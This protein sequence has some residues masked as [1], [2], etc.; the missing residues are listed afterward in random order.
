MNTTTRSWRGL[1]WQ[2]MLLLAVLF[3]WLLPQT[4]GA[5]YVDQTY[6]Y[7]VQLSG[8]NSISFSMPVYDQED[9][10][11]WILDGLLKAKWKDDDGNE[12][13]KTVLRWQR[14]LGSTSSS[15]TDVNIVFSTEADGLI[16]ITQGNSSSRFELTN[17]SG[18]QMHAVYRNNDGHSYNVTGV[19]RLPFDMLGSEGKSR[20]VKFSWD[21]DRTGTGTRVHEKVSGLNSTT[22]TVPPAENKLYP[23]VTSATMSF[24]KPGLLEVPWF[25]AT[26][27]LTA[28]R[29]E[30]IDADGNTVSEELKID[31][32]NGTIDLDATVPHKRF[33]VVVS[34]KDGNDYDVTNVPSVTQDLGIIRAPIGFMARPKGDDKARVELTWKTLYPD[35]TDLMS[36]DLF[37]L[38]RSLTGLEADF[39]TIGSVAY[40]DKV[41]DYSFVDSTIVTSLNTAQLT[42][43]GTLP[44]LTYRVR[45]AATQSWGWDGNPC[46]ASSQA[47]V[48]GLHLLRLNTY[49]AKWEDER[50]H[51][52]RVNWEYADEYHAV[53]DNRA[54]LMMSV[55]M[56]N[57]AGEVV[58]TKTYELTDDERNAR[59]KVIDLSRSC[60]KYDIKMYVDPGT[61]PLKNY[62]D[63]E[64]YYFPIRNAT[65]WQTFLSK[66][67]EAKGQY[68]VNARLYADISTTQSCGT[69]TS[70]FRG[71]FD[72]NGHTLTVN[73]S[74]SANNEAPFK[75][76]KDYTIECLTVA[77]TVKG[78]RH[79]AGLVGA[80]YGSK[81]KVN[82]IRSCRV[83]ATVE[84]VERYVGGFIGHGYEANHHIT[85]CLFDGKMKCDGSDTYGGV[86]IGWSD[87]SADNKVACCLENGTFEGITYP[88]MNFLGGKASFYDITGKNNNNC[89][90]HDWDPALAANAIYIASASDW[91]AFAKELNEGKHPTANVKL[92]ADIDLS[93]SNPDECILGSQNDYPFKGVFDGAGHTLNVNF[94]KVEAYMAP[95][96]YVGD[97]TIKNL[98]V[99]GIIKG[100][101][102]NSGLIGYTESN[103]NVIIEKVRVSAHIYGTSSVSAGFIAYAYNLPNIRMFDCLYDGGMHMYGGNN[104]WC[105]AMIGTANKTPGDTWEL[106]RVYD[107]GGYYDISKSLVGFCWT[108]DGWWNVNSKST[109]CMTNNYFLPKVDYCADQVEVVRRMN[110][111]EEGSWVLLNRTAVPVLESHNVNK[112]LT[113]LGSGWHM[114]EGTALPI[115][116]AFADPT[117][118][119]PTP[120]LPD[121]YHQNTG[122]VD[123]KLNTQT[124]QS[125]VVLTWTTDGNPIDYFQVMRRVKGTTKWEMI[126][127]QVDQMAYEDTTVLALTDY[128]YQVKGVNDCEGLHTSETDVTEGACKHSG[129][130]SGYVRMNDGTSVAGIEVEIAPTPSDSPEGGATVTVTT[131]DKGYFVADELSYYG[132]QSI[133]YNVTPVARDNIKLE[134]GTM[135]VEF[136]SKSNDE[137]LPDFIITSGHRFSGYVMYE[138]T[139]IPVKGAHF[140]VDGH[141]VH[142]AAGELLETAFDGSFSFRV[143]GGN[144][145]IQ[146]VMDSHKFA[147]DG[148]FKGE[149]GY[150]FSDNVAQ[151]Y[152]YDQTKVKLTGRIVGGDKQGLLPFDNNLSRNNLGD[153]LTM[154][155]TLEGDNT[156]WLIYDNLNPSLSSR[157]DSIDH[158]GGG[159][160]KTRYT[161]Q[162]KRMEVHPDSITG[163]YVLMLPPVRWKVQQVYCDGYATLFQDGQVS[164]VVD[165]TGCLDPKETTYAGSYAYPDGSSISEPKATYNAIYSRI[166]HAPV[167]ITY[168]QLGYD[169]F[170]YFGDKTYRAQSLSSDPVDVPLVYQDKQQNV[171]YTFGYPL[172]SLE[173][174]YPIE[175][176]VAERYIYNNDARTGKVDIVSVGGGSVTVHNGLKNGLHQQTVPLDA[177]GLGHFYL[178][179]EQT[180]RLLTGEDAL[181]TVTMTLT[182]DGTTYEAEPLQGY[183]M[184]TFAM[185]GSKDIIAADEPLLIDILRDPPGSGSSATLSKGSKLKLGYTVDMKFEAGVKLNFGKG[186]NLD[187]YSGTVSGGVSEFGQ[188]TSAETT[189][190]V[191]LDIIFSG[192]GTKGYS[193]TMNVNEDITTS[194]APNMVG[195]DADLYIGVVHNIVVQ[196]MSTIRAIPDAMY[197]QMKG[198]VADSLAT[199]SN[200]ALTQD[201]YGSLVHIAEGRDADKN[202]YHLVRDVSLGYGPKLKSQFVYSQRHIVN[203]LIPNL[204]QEIYSMI[205]TGTKAEAEA[206][207]KATGKTVYWSKVPVSDKNFGDKDYYAMITP[208]GV[209]N[210]IDTLQQKLKNL[211][212]WMNMIAMNEKDKISAYDLVANYAVDGGSSVT[213]SEEFESNYSKAE[214]VKYPFT[215]ADYFGE[216]NV[217]SWDVVAD[218]AASG[219]QLVGS[220]LLEMLAKNL[221]GTVTSDYNESHYDENNRRIIETSLHFAGSVFKCG[222]TPVAEY[223]STG[224]GSVENAFSRKES[225]TLSLASKSHLDVDVFRVKPLSTDTLKAKYD[226]YFDVF[227]NAKFD[228]W[229]NS[230]IN[231][232]GEGADTLKAIYPRSFVYR[233]RGGATANPWEDERR[234]MV[235]RPGLLLDERTKKISNPK[236]KMNQQSVSGVPMGEAA[237]FKVYLSNESEYPEAATGGLSVFNLYLD[238]ASNPNGAKIYVDGTPL[239]SQGIDV[240][241]APGEQVTKTME[242]YAGDGFDYDSLTIALTQSS[243]WIH[244]YDEVRFDVHFLHEAGPVLIATPGDKWI[245]NTDAEYDE[246]RG[247]F[248]PVTISGFNKH[249]HNFDHIEFQYKESQRGDGYWTNLCS[250]FADETLMAKASGERKMIP[251]NDNIHAHFY[252]EGTV[253]EKAYDL[254]A[255]LYCRNGNSFLTTSSPIVSGVKDTRRPQLFG[256]PEPKDG[257]LRLGDNI[258]FNFSEDIEYNYLNAITNF[259]VKGEVNND[260][261]TDAV[262]VQFTGNGSVESEAQRNFS[263]KDLTIDLMVRPDKTGR[264]MPL[265]SH[266][267]NGKRLQLWLTSDFRLKAII[268]DQTFLSTDTIVKSGFTQVAMV[269]D[270]STLNIDHS[271]ADENNGQSSM[272]NGQSSMVNG[273]SSMVNGQL[274]FYNG[275]KQLG[276]FKMTEPYN[277]TGRLIFGRTNETDRSKSQYYEGRMMEAR[278]WYR[279]MTGGQVGTTYGSRRLTGYEMGL[280]DYF[281]M[282]EGTGD[283]ALDKTQGA[284]AQLMGASW[285]MPRGWSL[286]LDNGGV[287]LTQQALARTA[288]QDYTMM[289]WFKT[290]DADGTLVSNGS[291]EK[292]EA[293]AE[294]HFWL[295][296][297]DGTL[298]FRSNGMTVE[299]GSG[300]NDDQWHHYAM[301]VNRTRGVANIYVDQALKATFSPDSLGGISGGTP[302]IGGCVRGVTNNTAIAP[303]RAALAEPTAD[304]GKTV[305]LSTLTSAYEAKDGDVLTGTL[306]AN[307]K[308][309]VANGATVTLSDVTINGFNSTALKWAGINCEGNATIILK[310]TNSVQGFY[311]DYPGIYV[312][313]SKTLTIKGDGS[314]TAKSSMWGAAG[315]GGGHNISCGNI[316]IEGGT[317]TTPGG[318][319]CAGIG[320]GEGGSCGNITI[321]GGTINATGGYGSAGIGGGYSGS[322][323]NITITDGV[324]SVTATKG[325]DAPYSIGSSRDG[326]CGIVTIG[327]TVGTISK[328]PYTYAPDYHTVTGVTLN[329]VNT[330]LNVGSSETLTATVI[331]DN[332]SDKS[333]TWTTSNAA[334]ATVADGTVTAVTPGTATITVTA[335]NG[336]TAT[337]EVTVIQP[338]TGVTLNKV[339]TTLA[340]GSTETLT[341]TVYPPNATD[342][343]LTWTTSNAAVATVADGVVTAVATGT[344]TITVTTAY[345]STATCEVTVPHPVRGVSLNKTSTTL[346]IGGKETLIAIVIPSN[347][348]KSVTWTTSNA[349]VATVTDGVVTGVN[350]GTATITVTTNDGGKT[351][352]CEVTVTSNRL[353]SDLT[354]NI[355]EL[356]MFQQALPLTLIEAYATKSPQGDEA[357]L[358]TYLAFDRQERQKDNDIETVAYTWSKKIYLDDRGEVRYELDPVTKQATTTPV[359]DYLFVGSADE[360]LRHITNETAAPVVPYEELTNLKFSFAGKDNQVLVELDELAS[361]INRRNIYVTLRDVEDKNGNAM[362]SPQTAC[363]YVTNSSLRW[364]NERQTCLASYGYEDY[365]YFDILNNSATTHTYTIENCPRWLDME[366]YTGIIGPLGTVT[367]RGVVNK[368][369]NVGTYDEIIYLTDE[370]GVAEPLYLNLTV[371]TSAPEWSWSVD[372]DLLK[373]SMNIAG[374]VILNGE[375]DIDSRDIVGVF[376]RENRCH[377]IAHV[378]YSALTGESDLFLTVY[379]SKKKGTELYFKIWQYSTGREMVLTADG[380][381]SMTFRNDSIVGVDTPVRFEGG[382]LYVQTFDLKEGWNWVSFNVASEKLFD[383]NTLLGGLPWENGDVLTEMSGNVTMTYKNGT[384]LATGDVK[385]LRISPRKGYAIKVAQDIQ[386]PVGG[387]IIKSEDTRTIT[388][389]NGWNGIGYTPILNLS[390]ETALSD[391]YDNATPGDIIK[392]HSEFAYFTKTGGTGR[393]RGNLQYMKPGEGYMLLRKAEGE[394]SFRYPFYEPGSTFLDAWAVA[395]SRSAAEDGSADVPSA[396]TD[397]NGNDATVPAASPLG[398]HRYRHTMSLTAVI[399]G[400]EPEE[401]DLLVAY[402]DGE[403]CAALVVGHASQRGSVVGEASKLCSTPLYL[404]I[405]GEKQADLWFAIERNGDIVAST[406][407]VLTFRV[408]DVVGSPDEPFALRFAASAT[409]IDTLNADQEL[410]KWYTVNGIELPQRPTRKGVY[411]YNGNKV[412]IK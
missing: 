100:T 276:S 263:G 169:T 330:T 293:G 233:T 408:D 253:M 270:H 338:T 410:G 361:R 86:F 341:A 110:A 182:Q 40:D 241:L 349:N 271:P 142:N 315:I 25:M 2:L 334:V 121:F 395:G 49:S 51:T 159:G 83:S 307:V 162:R 112:V 397:V 311:Q 101:Y 319:G 296:F 148:Y 322:C 183:I 47:V 195:A 135:P 221:S 249:Q 265:F 333:V 320:S 229:T 264:D 21:V 321:T 226:T 103:A 26:N 407:N 324:T 65:D 168:K 85:N 370:D 327:G 8:S 340:V 286:S 369:L 144:R 257:I 217:N 390:V 284:N 58:D 343:S 126:A 48:D 300:Y 310:G 375:V 127:D 211:G 359:R 63:I 179:A 34:Y 106:H 240:I 130:V 76:A 292:N 205:F 12:Q 78:G 274:T 153:K 45:R 163:E 225:F 156:S 213:H 287:G 381:E 37:E 374:Q 102:C 141:D 134:R 305:D 1:T 176:Q 246:K 376:D 145:R 325:T 147:D 243:D 238:E 363:Y 373:Y 222:I 255:V 125:S 323:G 3:A 378:N 393:W 165:L 223:S 367:I 98:R 88:N 119:Y 146:A 59:Q 79:T 128:E 178:E 172:F 198:R 17:N 306:G 326:T 123:K 409:G 9:E 312:Q 303:A 389:S 352:T 4:A 216:N 267:T 353:V 411:I 99:T 317:I 62:E 336:S 297:D 192:A 122:K 401:G 387:S 220:W 74:S 29:Y 185:T 177:D 18:S 251:E 90:V 295:G 313:E 54:K 248:L 203:E 50:A 391:Y 57:N 275:G 371:T 339:N 32:G 298:A 188:I 39:T 77:G 157:N 118:T 254:R 234:T 30:Y 345:S 105:C 114:V 335:S 199:N 202:L 94:D 382:S 66:V 73:I 190:Y 262:S 53:W 89:S 84:C 143:L 230:I 328:S 61:S 277:G 268:D 96:R 208:P 11:T 167:E 358:L 403:P 35:A 46:A 109:N 15:S 201:N 13:E 360:I 260:N 108:E 362:V 52:V 64:T 24:N 383:L 95:F 56:K 173:R 36:T 385:N 72:G 366:A 294:N 348:D 318:Y 232:V 406:G 302:V 6:N 115:A 365:I 113:T 291:G 398:A 19:W 245:L 97:C 228:Q 31:V 242:V 129:R 377:G 219:V 252:G 87:A 285:A 104:V 41:R 368:G 70:P 247:W 250:Y 174:K 259:E 166:Y 266:G 132:G 197:Q 80:S 180:T 120:T 412:V 161:V 239:N 332:A 235:Y 171:H 290:D 44:N 155:L 191:N 224:T 91:I 344:A 75:F 139:S 280:V 207:A 350:P 164:E 69:S 149:G 384:W 55:T 200:W 301:T 372:E 152:F 107:N 187:S 308:I 93:G 150:Y 151:I 38:Q 357:G 212:A 261:V 16:T 342:K 402:A 218:V 314:L 140:R 256:T 309:S 170:D 194:S 68:D 23:Q 7:Q 81:D 20:E 227:H 204:A 244:V 136:N 33:R 278:L 400:F 354:G 237:R 214:Y 71:Y 392:S 154:V 388:V 236:I 316:I 399:E 160:H 131:D 27:K 215:T 138:G 299:A 22:V 10:D 355:D 283:Y 272:V 5:T 279:A 60:L 282:N 28:A 209:T 379:D 304:T 14:T 404:N 386:F 116:H 394:A 158:P 396:S 92:S 67:Q 231:H 351:A 337:C 181:R 288:E 331:P 133:T 186:T 111:E 210:K 289:F 405:G 258:I 189:N 364:Q 137:T 281:P 347:A 42:G 346:Y 329:K 82:V 184:N 124:R 117:A 43:G 206:Q 196:P 269:I 380:K 175:I 356:C 273:Q 193:Y